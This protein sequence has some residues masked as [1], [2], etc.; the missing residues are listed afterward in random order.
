MLHQRCTKDDIARY[1]GFYA[2]VFYAHFAGAGL[3]VFGEESTSGGRADMTVRHD[4]GVSVFEF[5]MDDTAEAALAQIKR[6][7]YAEKH[8]AQGRAVH[9]VGVAFSERDRNLAGFAVERL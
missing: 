3:E 7:G 4:G 8:R 2:S 9:L 1:E 5:K 6:K